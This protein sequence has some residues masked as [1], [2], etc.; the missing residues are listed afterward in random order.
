MTLQ[1]PKFKNSQ[2]VSENFPFFLKKI[3]WES[4]K[5][6]KKIPKAS[7][8]IP[9]KQRRRELRQKR[10]SKKEGK[11]FFLI[12]FCLVFTV[13]EYYTQRNRC[14]LTRWRVDQ[15]SSNVRSF[16]DG[17]LFERL[18]CC[19]FFGGE[20]KEKRNFFMQ[21]WFFLQRRFGGDLLRILCQ[22]TVI[23]GDS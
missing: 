21:I 7:Q 3:F 12:F 13:E 22:M 14:Q 9:K 23:F 4:P 10:N 19:F 18:S 2:N 5:V 20:N 15:H 16:I 1:N 6:R 11:F 17:V 8:T